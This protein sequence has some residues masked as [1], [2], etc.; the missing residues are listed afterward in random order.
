MGNERCDECIE[1]MSGRFVTKDECNGSRDRCERRIDAD[2]KRFE[3]MMD[4]LHNKM[5]RL[6]WLA[7]GTLTASVGIL[8]KQYV[9]K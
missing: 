5:D 7:L 4:R 2:N 3:A 9:L 1:R 6:I 8:I